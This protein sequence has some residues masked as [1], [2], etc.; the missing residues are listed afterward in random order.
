MMPRHLGNLAI[1]G[2]NIISLLRDG[3]NIIIK[4]ID[5]NREKIII[6][7][8][9]GIKLI[10][11]GATYDNYDAWSRIDGLLRLVIRTIMLTGE[12]EWFPPI[13]RL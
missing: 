10:D 6:I 11:G 13:L 8:K 2:G 5:T 3:D 9:N 12:Y 1:A 7:S 4:D